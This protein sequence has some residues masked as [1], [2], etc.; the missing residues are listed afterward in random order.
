MGNEYRPKGCEALRLESK[1][2]Y[3]SFHLCT[4]YTCGWQVKLRDPLLTRAILK[5]LRDEQIIKSYY[6]SEAYFTL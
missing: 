5:H 6:T 3:G 4:G 1:G 2:R